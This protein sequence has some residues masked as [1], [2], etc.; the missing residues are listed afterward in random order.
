METRRAWMPLVVLIPLAGTAI[1]PPTAN[2]SGAQSAN[3][4][5]QAPFGGEPIPRLIAPQSLDQPPPGF[6]LSAR[7]AISIA[8]GTDEV[9]REREERELTPRPRT[10][11]DEWQ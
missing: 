8:E 2:G 7:E 1:A 6:R 11:G 9:Q 10:R 4:A 3:P 5:D